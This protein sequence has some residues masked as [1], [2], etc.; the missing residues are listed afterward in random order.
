VPRDL[1]A[2]LGR[3]RTD[4]EVRRDGRGPDVPLR[5]DATQHEVDLAADAAIFRHHPDRNPS[6]D[7]T[8]APGSASARFRD[9]KTAR[10]VLCD[11]DR[12]ALYDAGRWVDPLDP[13]TEE[14]G[15]E[16]AWKRAVKDPALREVLSGAVESACVLGGLD[17]DAASLAGD[18][19]LGAVSSL[20]DVAQSES[21]IADRAKV[22]FSSASQKLKTPEG[23]AALREAGQ[24]FV[25]TWR[26]LFT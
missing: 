1:Y 22:A 15:G 10:E 5:R 9:A 17:Q 3:P 4:A 19:L 26:S 13:P 2:A 20:V 14:V 21:T 11:P 18:A 23:R 25:K 16:P 6:D 8:G 24:S 7:G 12:R